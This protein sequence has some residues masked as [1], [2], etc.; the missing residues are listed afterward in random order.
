M[1]IY[2]YAVLPG[3]HE[4]IWLENGPNDDMDLYV[5]P[6]ENEGSQL[7]CNVHE[8]QTIENCQQEFWKLLSRCIL[9]TP[10]VLTSSQKGTFKKNLE[11]LGVTQ[12]PFPK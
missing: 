11:R 1:N 3:S 5:S 7:L 6:I 9:S 8:R 2:D 10:V 12:V 4:Q